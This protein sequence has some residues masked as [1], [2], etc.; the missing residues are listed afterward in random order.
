[1]RP[2]LLSTAREKSKRARRRRGERR[3]RSG[4]GAGPRRSGRRIGA[5]SAA[6]AETLSAERAAALELPA[7]PGVPRGGC[8]PEVE[9]VRR[10]GG[11]LDRAVYTCACGCLF[12]AAVSTTVSCPH[13]GTGQAW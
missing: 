13:C 9:K 12:S 2:K 10:A 3:A 11:P 1:M 6:P 8:D 4:A 5:S 7:T